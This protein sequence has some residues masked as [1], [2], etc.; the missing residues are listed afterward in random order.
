MI[1]AVAGALFI[2]VRF[3]IKKKELSVTVPFLMI[4]CGLF[5]AYNIVGSGSE[6]KFSV[7]LLSV[8]SYAAVIV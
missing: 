3:C 1:F 5:T 8:Y 6:F 4:M 7:I 2:P